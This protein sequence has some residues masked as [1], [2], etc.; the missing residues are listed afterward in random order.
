[1][2]RRHFSKTCGLLGVAAL[3]RG[4]SLRADVSTNAAASSAATLRVM[5]FN[6]R[7]GT[8]ADGEDCWDNRKEQLGD[9]IVANAPDLLGLQEVVPFQSEWIAEYLAKKAAAADTETSADIV[10]STTVPPYAHFE[11][12]REVD[13]KK[14]EAMTIFYRTDR[15][16]LVAD[17][18]GT[19]WLSETP[20]VVGSQS[21]DTA[22]RRIAT[23]GRFRYK[24]D[25]TQEFY[26]FNTHL[27]HVSKEARLNGAKL[28]I[29]RIAKRQKSE[30]PVM[31]TGDFNC[32][33]SS[34]PIQAFR[35]A[36]FLDTYRV[37]HPDES[38]VG[39]FHGF[40]GEP[41]KNKI[42][43]I[44]ATPGV[45]VESSEILRTNR[46]GRYPSDHFPIVASLRWDK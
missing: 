15:L 25:P 43:Y 12:T 44:F 6:I 41:N 8:A 28:I 22:C 4:T 38:N 32:G 39:T 13:P 27:D 45:T 23:W 26:F 7:T 18:T 10:P 29:E 11:R 9:T 30:T 37:V 14:G 35:K 2:D 36:G 31:I 1:M 19:F 34:E 24:A 16:E 21:W 20:D 46:D 40:S 3:L 5:T 33:E 42:D 17:D